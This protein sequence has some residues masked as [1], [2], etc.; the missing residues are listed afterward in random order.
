MGKKHNYSFDE[1]V[2]SVEDVHNAS[3][4]SAVKAVNRFATSYFKE[5]EMHDGFLEKK[6]Q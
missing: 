4:H 1:L 3:F 2:K 6:K 5:N